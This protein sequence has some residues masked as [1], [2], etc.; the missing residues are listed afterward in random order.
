M[1]HETKNEP[2][3]PGIPVRTWRDL[4]AYTLVIVLI[5]GAFTAL[6]VQVMVHAADIQDLKQTSVRKDVLDPQLTDIQNRLGRIEGK[7]DN[8]PDPKTKFAPALH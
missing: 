6:Q 3:S 5:V 7:I 4:W 8:Q 1:S 2:I